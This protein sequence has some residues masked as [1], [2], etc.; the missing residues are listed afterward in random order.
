MADYDNKNTWTLFKNDRKTDDKHP[1]YTGTLNVDGVEY[2][3]DAWLKESKA[4]KKF[5]SGKIKMK[6]QPAPRQVAA[7]DLDEIPF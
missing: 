6:G 7:N 4:G 2:F 1:D 3:M 5:F